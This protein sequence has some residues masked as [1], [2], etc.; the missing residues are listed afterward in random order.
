MFAELMNMCCFHGARN[1]VHSYS[2]RTQI[3]QEN[4]VNLNLASFPSISFDWLNKR[5]NVDADLKRVDENGQHNLYNLQSL[6]SAN[7]FQGKS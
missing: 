3:N 4:K 6:L 5:E 7:Y 2:E 1:A